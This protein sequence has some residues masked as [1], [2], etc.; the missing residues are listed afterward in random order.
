M[1]GVLQ[2]DDSDLVYKVN[3]RD[4]G[5]NELFVIL[6]PNRMMTTLIVLVKLQ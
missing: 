1:D 4:V 6:V 2:E 5:V 3:R